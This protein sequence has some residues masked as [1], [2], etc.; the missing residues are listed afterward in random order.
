MVLDSNVPN[1]EFANVRSLFGEGWRDTME[2]RVDTS[3]LKLYEIGDEIGEGAYGIVWKAVDKKSG[4][5][6]AI[7]KCLDAFGCEQDAQRTYRL[8]KI[9]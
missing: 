3:I 8:T 9:M 6:V 2:S 5:S 4:R 1:F 7:K